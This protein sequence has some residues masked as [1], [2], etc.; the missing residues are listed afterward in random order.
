MML[1]QMKNT[2]ILS[3]TLQRATFLG[4]AIVRPTP[5]MKDKKQNT[6]Y[7]AATHKWR[8]AYQPK[9]QTNIPDYSYL[10]DGKDPHRPKRIPRPGPELVTIDR[11]GRNF[12]SIPRSGLISGSRN[13]AAAISQVFLTSPREVCPLVADQRTKRVEVILISPLTIYL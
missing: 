10:L 8:G 11:F 3:L 7:G 5:Q 13:H 9:T 12:Y 4:S 2:E 1:M 6:K